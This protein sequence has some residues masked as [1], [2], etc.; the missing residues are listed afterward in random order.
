MQQS[1]FVS[2]QQRVVS[3]GLTVV[4]CQWCVV[5]GKVIEIRP[6]TDNPLL[7]TS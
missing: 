7:T 2:S 6:A 3:C 4:S 5:I 1:R